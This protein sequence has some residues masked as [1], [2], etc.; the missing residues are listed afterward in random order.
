MDRHRRLQSRPGLTPSPATGR[1][2]RTTSTTTSTRFPRTAGSSARRATCTAA[3]STRRSRTPRATTAGSCARR[4]TTRLPDH[5]FYR[6]RPILHEPSPV[7]MS[8]TVSEQGIPV[9]EGDQ[10]R[11]RAV[12][13]NQ[14]PHTRVMSIMM[15]YLV[16]GDV[17]R[18]QAARTTSRSRTC[19]GVPQAVPAA[20]V[21]LMAP[22]TRRVQAVH[23]ADRRGGYLFKPA[24]RGRGARR[25]R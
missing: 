20:T 9:S 11:L 16:P 18:A 5:I 10:L 1:R 19:R 2:A 15:A 12:Y 3:A 17:D 6:V 23:R 4:P 14:L 8:R 13:D 24:A 25:P 21:P 7:S 22:P